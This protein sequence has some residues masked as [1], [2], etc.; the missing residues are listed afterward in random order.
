MLIDLKKTRYLGLAMALIGIIAMA[1]LM[2]EQKTM[3]IDS[4]SEANTGEKIVVNG[5]IKNLKIK[6]SNAFFELEDI[7]R[8]K[9]VYFNPSTK[10]M[11][12][13]KENQLVQ[14]EASVSIYKNELQLIV[15]EVRSID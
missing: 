5:A 3:R 2:P 14:A 13:L 6:N 15:S 9:A 1:M 11:L 8:I 12:F 4:I 7:S 10:Q